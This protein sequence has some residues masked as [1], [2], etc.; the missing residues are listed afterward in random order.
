[1]APQQMNGSVVLTEPEKNPVQVALDNYTDMENHLAAAEAE[2][3]QL[4]DMNRALVQENQMLREN[5]SEARK[6]FLSVQAFSVALTT[7]LSVIQDVVSA[8]V[9]ESAKFSAKATEG[10]TQ[11][12]SQR[13]DVPMMLT[14]GDLLPKN[15][16]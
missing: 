4:R 14:D 6:Q 11:A 7:R 1:M 2:A 12:P 16:L 8:A 10:E 15:T 5:Y 3:K 13:R 9:A